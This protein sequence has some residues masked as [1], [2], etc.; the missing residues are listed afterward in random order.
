[1]EQPALRNTGERKAIKQRPASY[2]TSVAY[3]YEYDVKMYNEGNDDCDGPSCAQKW[4]SAPTICRHDDRESRLDSQVHYGSNRQ[5]G[6]TK[7]LILS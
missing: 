5:E 2:R 6:Q 3:V 7:M 1:M 4:T